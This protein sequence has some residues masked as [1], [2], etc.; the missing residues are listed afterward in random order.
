ML[1]LLCMSFSPD[2]NPIH[3][4]ESTYLEFTAEKIETIKNSLI[5]LK[6]NQSQEFTKQVFNI[7]IYQIYSFLKQFETSILTSQEIRELILILQQPDELQLQFEYFNWLFL[8]IINFRSKALLPSNNKELKDLSASF[9]SIV[10]IAN[11]QFAI[12]INKSNENKSLTTEMLKTAFTTYLIHN[13][14]NGWNLCP[15]YQGI[16]SFQAKY[17]LDNP[18]W[19]QLLLEDE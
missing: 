4:S 13:E 5:E 17:K 15:D 9:Y 7:L 6:E 18:N 10:G 12:D 14:P 1:E 16:K 2:Q 8:K 11:Y 3:L 19:K